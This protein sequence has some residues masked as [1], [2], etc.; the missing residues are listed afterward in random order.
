[1]VCGVSRV[2]PEAG[3]SRVRTHIVH[4]AFGQQEEEAAPMDLPSLKAE[5]ARV[6]GYECPPWDLR[7]GASLI[8]NMRIPRILVE[9]PRS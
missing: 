9:V 4:S 3:P 8:S 2:C 5:F 7:R 6:A 1:M